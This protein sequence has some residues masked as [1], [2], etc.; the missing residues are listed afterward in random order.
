VRDLEDAARRRGRER[1]V[2]VALDG[3]GSVAGYTEVVTSP[4]G[5]ALAVVED[6]AV[7]A[8]ARG[9]GLAFWIKTE[10]LCL[11][12]AQRPDVTMVRTSNDASNATILRVNRRMGFEPIAT[13]TDA[14][15]DI[16]ALP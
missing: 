13:W 4:A 10:S 11:L 3:T 15:L 7:V 14:I 5:E 12:A 16:R 9:K 2:T 1:R 6:T 8:A